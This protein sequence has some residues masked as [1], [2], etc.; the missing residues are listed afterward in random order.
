MVGSGSRADASIVGLK[1]HAASPSPAEISEACPR[2]D[3][4]PKQ[5][6]FY[7]LAYLLLVIIHEAGHVLAAVAVRV[8]VFTV[9]ISGAGGLCRIERPRC[10]R[11][12]VFVYT[13]GLLAQ[14]LVFSITL[15]Y[16]DA[17]GSP[18]GPF[19]AAIVFTFTVV[20]VVIFAINLIPQRNARSCRPATETPPDRQAACFEGWYITVRS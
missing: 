8:K 19:G 9:E 17:F 12:S 2:Y 16:I 6:V 14:A 11:Y 1:P 7:C 3:A 13:A 10:V 20:N 5:W 15:A 4:D 18:G